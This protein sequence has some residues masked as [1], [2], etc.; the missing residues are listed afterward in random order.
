M[1]NEK[2]KLLYDD[3]SK[4]YE[5]G[6]YDDFLKYLSDDKQ[7]T[8]FYNEIVKPNYEVNTQ[9]EFESLYELKKKAPTS[10]G[11]LDGQSQFKD[12][13]SLIKGGIKVDQNYVKSSQNPAM[14]LASEENVVPVDKGVKTP[15]KKSTKPVKSNYTTDDQGKVVQISPEE[16]TAQDV[17][18]NP[19]VGK[20]GQGEWVKVNN[21]EGIPT[22]KRVYQ[23]EM[24]QKTLSPREQELATTANETSPYLLGDFATGVTQG[25][26]D[27]VKG[28]GGLI[29]NTLGISDIKK[30]TNYATGEEE[31]KF[32]APKVENFFVYKIGQ[33]I[34]DFSNQIGVTPENKQDIVSKLAT[35][36][37]SMVPFIMGGAAGNAFKI[38]EF[39][40]PSVLGSLQ[41]AGSEY[42][43]A[44]ASGA[45]PST[46][47]QTF[48]GALAVG[49]LEGLPI[50]QW[51]KRMNGLTGGQLDNILVQKLGSRAGGATMGMLEEGVQEATST[52]LNNVVA[53]ETYDTTRR[54]LDGALESGIIGGLLG[55]TLNGLTAG[56]QKKLEDPTLTPSQK[57]DVE[58]S[59]ELVQQTQD[60][61]KDVGAN[62]FVK[63]DNDSKPIQELKSQK[64]DIES[65]IANPNIAPEVKEQLSAKVEEIDNQI[66][67][68]KE[69]EI[70]KS[71]TEVKAEGEIADLTEQEAK[72]DEQIAQVSE[73]S[74]PILE[75]Q[76]N[77]IIERLEKLKEIVPKK[78]KVK[79]VKV[80]EPAPMEAVPVETVEEVK[81]EDTPAPKVE[82][83]VPQEVVAT[84]QEIVP[85]Q[86]Q[87][88]TPQEPQSIKQQWDEKV[89]S[90]DT[91]KEYT[92]LNELKV[93]DVILTKNGGL[94]FVK[95]IGPKNVTYETTYNKNGDLE[96]ME[97]K[98][99]KDDISVFKKPK[100]QPTST[101]QLFEQGISL[102]NQIKTTD[103][104]AKKRELAK[105]RKELYK[106]N[107]LAE[108]VDK[109]LSTILKQ[110]EDKGKVTRRGD[111]P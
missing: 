108:K 82:P 44:I 43:A 18:V 87:E 69:E 8:A 79:K 37:G 41:N 56:L 26:A 96:M 34:E 66:A 53:G 78:E 68:T 54:F 19:N 9:D 104:A 39:I 63:L 25:V 73:A 45:D 13:P 30:E 67:Q 100:Q 21:D 110:L 81:V 49:S 85:E 76:R 60:K 65:D 33:S 101:T 17:L 83:E 77:A 107:P 111:C 109:N 55:G 4:E 89:A 38:S 90:I 62:D 105:Q 6:S 24:Q 35:G 84:E 46:A 5:V 58:K 42:D 2:L 91:E 74:K 70:S 12:R 22:I 15:I 16:I 71:V 51:A 103:G 10:F 95:K 29:V 14:Q 32:D 93:G 59:L 40:A 106:Q 72:L 98:T 20:L 86:P 47:M 88:I 3:V 36:A 7:R 94:G 61:A 64:V 57:L 50:G 28:A 92:D 80:E 99:S 1:P 31:I 102:Y 97:L 52:I 27:I 48:W 11:S 75:E 23:P